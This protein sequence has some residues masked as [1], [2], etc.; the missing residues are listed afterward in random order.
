MYA[1]KGICVILKTEKSDI[2]AHVTLRILNSGGGE[3]NLEFN[4]TNEK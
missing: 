2:F 1:D 3:P 4:I